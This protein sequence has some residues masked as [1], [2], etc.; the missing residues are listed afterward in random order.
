MC[1]NMPGVL[2][3]IPCVKYVSCSRVQDISSRGTRTINL[4]APKIDQ[5]LLR[6]GVFSKNNSSE[7]Y[8]RRSLLSHTPQIDWDVDMWVG[9]LLS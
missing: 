1:I 2:R 7:A 5:L 8:W 9:V 4:S 6:E 3:M